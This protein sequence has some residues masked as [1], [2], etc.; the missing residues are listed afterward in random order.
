MG[1]S[2][3]R[4]SRQLRQ[5]IGLL[6]GISRPSELLEA[7]L[8]AIRA[9]VGADIASS[10]AIGPA[11][12]IGRPAFEPA[13]AMRRA[14]LA[15]YA[16]FRDQQPL[17]GDY[18]RH[19]APAPVRTTDVISVRD[20]ARLDL[21]RHFYRPLGIT[22]QLA[23][24]VPEEHGWTVGYTLSRSSADFDAASVELMTLLQVS[25]AGAH[26]SIAA[27]SLRRQF[28]N[29]AVMLR[30]DAT[31]RQFCLVMIDSRGRVEFAAGPL[32]GRVEA[33]F[34]R[35]TAGTRAPARLTRILAASRVSFRRQVQLGDSGS[36]D[37]V[38]WPEREAGG[39]LLF[40]LH[41]RADLRSRFGLTAG[42]YR[43]LAN[44]VRYETNEGAARAEGVSV[45]TI[46]KRM[47]AVLRKMRVETRV[48]AVREFLRSQQRP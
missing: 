42:E 7:G 5:T 46:E 48:G 22:Y 43:T 47:S 27:E 4:S 16:A 3:P 2:P 18:R 29:L 44:I 10:V 1:K 45:P 20:F 37:V 8:P 36:A 9:L 31:D 34:G 32:L 25:L 15:A 11:T 28:G 35:L 14:D 39:S 13:D 21:Y 30:D 41:D 33:Q 40:E 19:G 6:R 24:G 26:H 23:I 38:S 17:I 12:T